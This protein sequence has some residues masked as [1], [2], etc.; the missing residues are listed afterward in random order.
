MKIKGKRTHEQVIQT[1]QAKVVAR[2]K[3]HFDKNQVQFPPK[4]ICLIAIKDQKVLE[5]WGFS[6]GA[7]KRIV[8]YPVLAASGELGPKLREGDYQVP[9][10]F[11][12]IEYFNPNSSYHLSMKLNYPNEFDQRM[13]R[14]DGRSEPGTDIFIHGKN[15]SVG[16]LALGDRTIEELYVLVH[17][18]GK[19]NV[20]VI[21]TPSI[22]DFKTPDG[23]PDW[24]EI[25]YAEINTKMRQFKR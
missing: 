23:S 14:L 4:K 11:Y 3:P 1:Y 10:G 15:L 21:I 6:S 25:L 2:L 20:E 18:V 9:E 19:V 22:S 12:Q 17:M 7:W 13:A 16:C 8:N 24:F 5:L